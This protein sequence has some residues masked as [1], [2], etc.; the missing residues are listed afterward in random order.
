M[1]V[2]LLSKAIGDQLTCVFVDHGLLRKNEGDEVEKVFDPNGSYEVNFIRVN[3]HECFYGKLVGVTEPEQKRKNY[4]R[5][6]CGQ[7]R[8]TVF[9]GADEYAVGGCHGG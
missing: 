9:C 5:G 3:A 2:V 4:Q 8:W 6:Y 7:V 1:A